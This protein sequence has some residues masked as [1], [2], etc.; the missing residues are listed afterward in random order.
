MLQLIPQH[1]GA[2]IGLALRSPQLAGI[3]A[4]KFNYLPNG[5]GETGACPVLQLC[6]GRS[7]NM[8]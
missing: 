7:R 1:F 8:A 2:E 6:C 3:I 4:S 5:H